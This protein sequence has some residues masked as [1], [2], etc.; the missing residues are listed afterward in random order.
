MAIFRPRPPLPDCPTWRTPAPARPGYEEHG[1]EPERAH[2]FF[3][4]FLTQ[5]PYPPLPT[6][7]KDA[8]YS[9]NT[10]SVYS[11]VFRWPERAFMYNEEKLSDLGRTAIQRRA[12]LFD[13]AHDKLDEILPKAGVEQLGAVHGI[14]KDTYQSLDALN[15]LLNGPIKQHPAVAKLATQAYGVITS[16]LMKVPESERLAVLSELS[17]IEK[18]LEHPMNPT[19]QENIGL[20]K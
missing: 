10:L 1:T 3:L 9:P 7:A 20:D 17:D 4:W 16:L 14:A 8:G 5:N 19:A 2:K 11:S 12:R 6:V 13:T 18:L 15:R